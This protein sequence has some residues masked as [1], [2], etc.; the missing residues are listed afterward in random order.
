[1]LKVKSILSLIVLVNVVLNRTVVVYSDWRFDNLCGSHLQSQKHG[2]VSHQFQ[3]LRHSSWT[4]RVFTSHLNCFNPRT[5]TKSHTPTVV[6]GGGGGRKTPP[7]VFDILQ[8]FE[9]ILPSVESLWSSLQ[10]ELFWWPSWILSKIRNQVK[11]VDRINTFFLHFTF[12][13]THK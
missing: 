3:S 7:W 10:D 1:M 9:T 4:W 11:T 5:Y 13:I 8:Y 6:Q 12:E 2:L